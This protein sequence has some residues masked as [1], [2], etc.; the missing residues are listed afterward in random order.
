MSARRG[1]A[2]ALIKTPSSAFEP[3][4][5]VPGF[6]RHTQSLGAS[7]RKAGAAEHARPALDPGVIALEI[8]EDLE[9]ALAQFATIAEDL[10]S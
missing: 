7:R 3:L 5:N 8:T 10:K 1:S 9:A 2:A 4:S 6:P